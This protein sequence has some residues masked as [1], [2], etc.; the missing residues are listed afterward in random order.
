M[1]YYNS[2]IIYKLNT[3]L[4]MQRGIQLVNLLWKSSISEDLLLEFWEI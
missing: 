3:T 4:C 1:L 2:I